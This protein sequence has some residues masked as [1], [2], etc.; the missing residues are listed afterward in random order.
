M[1]CAAVGTDQRGVRAQRHHF[2]ITLC[3]G[4]GDRTAV[5]R[6]CTA[7]VRRQTRQCRD[8]AN[9]FIKARRSEGVHSQPVGAVDGISQ[10]DCAAV[11]TDQRGVRAQR[12]RFAKT[13]CASRGDRTTVHRQC[14]AGIRRQTRQRSDVTHQ[15]TKRCRTRSIYGQSVS[16]VDA[17]QQSDRITAGAAQRGI[18]AQ[19][20]R[21]AIALRAGRRDRAAVHRQCATG[22]RRQTRQCSDAANR[23]IKSRRTEG[24]NGQLIRTVDRVSQ[25]D[26]A[27]VGTGQR[28]VRTECDCAVIGLRTGRGHGAAIDRGAAGRSDRQTIKIRRCTDRTTQSGRTG[29]RHCQRPRPINRRIEGDRIATQRCI[30]TQR[31]RLAIALRTDCRDFTAVDIQGAT[32]AGRQTD[33]CGVATHRTTQRG[34]A[35][36]VHG[37]FIHTVDRVSQSDRTGVGTRQRGVR[38]QCDCAVICLRTGRGHC[39]AIDRGAAG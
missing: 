7:G 20:H 4:R 28:G 23:F 5:H 35:R 3:T 10:M 22:V 17:V 33:Q 18:R 9:R 37:E 11:G 32:S 6:Q 36:G 8:A 29:I 30:R 34:G 12:H 38:T 19:C 15:T 16:A 21:F 26:C 25:S 27:G 31:D 2:T 14:T 1:D 24:V 39:A 13:L